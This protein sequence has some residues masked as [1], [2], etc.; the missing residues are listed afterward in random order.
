MSETEQIAAVKIRMTREQL[1]DIASRSFQLI[2]KDSRGAG[3]VH[4]CTSENTHPSGKIPIHQGKYPL[5]YDGFVPIGFF[6]SGGIFPVNLS[7][8]YGWVVCFET[9]FLYF[10]CVRY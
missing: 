6:A 3:H 2:T 7:L 4:K 9:S 8:V 10:R 5:C 1:G